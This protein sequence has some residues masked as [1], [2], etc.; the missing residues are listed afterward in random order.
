MGALR[1]IDA[2]GMTAIPISDEKIAAG[3]VIDLPEW[4]TKSPATIGVGQAARV[5]LVKPG[6]EPGK[7]V[8][9]AVIR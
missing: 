8:V 5:A 1:T 2:T 7:Y 6:G 3:Q 4:K 9:E